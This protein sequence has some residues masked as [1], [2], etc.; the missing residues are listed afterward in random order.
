MRAKL[1]IYID[2]WCEL[3]DQLRPISQGEFWRLEQAKL[4]PGA[5]YVLGRNE[6]ERCHEFVRHN[7]SRYHFVFSNPA[8]GATTMLGQLRRY[9]LWDLATAG[10]VGIISGAGVPDVPKIFVYENFLDKILG[11]PGNI[12]QS[13]IA[14]LTRKSPRWDFLFLNG[15]CR[16]HRK[17]LLWRLDN[18]GLLEKSLYTCLETVRGQGFLGSPCRESIWSMPVTVLPHEYEV[19]RYRTNLVSTANS[20]SDVKSRLFDY[21]GKWEWGES[22]IYHAPYCDTA[23][24]LV[25][26]TV[27]QGGFSFRTEKIWKPIMMR[28]P[29]IAAAN[30]GFYQDMRN[31]GFQTFDSLIDESFDQETHDLD[32]MERILTVINDICQSGAAQFQNAARQ[33]CEH[34]YQ[35][36][37]ELSGEVSAGFPDDFCRWVNQNFSNRS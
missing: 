13:Q 29:W 23:F 18:M 14:D 15:R 31:L 7:L 32:R 37:L 16:E 5:V 35:R 19:P 36:M 20:E 1:D 6:F 27:Y 25:S 24:S 26:E 30:P 11:M 9:G 2:S 22:Y 34:N 28:H 8:E 10:R 12:E 4:V 33:I 21:Q 17:F 3:A